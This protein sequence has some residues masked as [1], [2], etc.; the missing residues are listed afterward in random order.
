[1]E[2]NYSST[3][4]SSLDQYQE[5]QKTNDIKFISPKQGA[6]LDDELRTKL[7][8]ELKQLNSISFNEFYLQHKYHEVQN[9]IGKVGIKTVNEVKVK[10]LFSN[11]QRIGKSRLII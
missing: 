10:A 4:Q 6:S 1:M 2:R 11:V 3:S 5:W 9:F 7:Q 8:N